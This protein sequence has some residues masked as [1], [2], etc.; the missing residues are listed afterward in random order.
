MN[1]KKLKPIAMTGGIAILSIL[2]LNT[3]ARHIRPVRSFRDLVV[4]GL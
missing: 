4:R 2:A 3:A 1:T